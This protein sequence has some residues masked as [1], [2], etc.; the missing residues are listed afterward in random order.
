[1]AY[2]PSLKKLQYLVK[3]YELQHFGKTAKACFVSQSTLSAGI[4]DLEE[5][6]GR[7]LIERNRQNMVFTPTG[8][9]LVKQA[10]EIL[11]AANQFVTTAEKADQFFEGTLRLGVIP[12]IAPYVLPAYLKK[13]SKVY[14]KLKILVREDLSDPLLD[15]LRA[16]ELDLLIIALPYPSESVESIELY[17]D[18]LQLVYNKNSIYTDGIQNNDL[19]NLPN[20]SVLLLEDGH[21]LK[22]HILSTCHLFSNKQINDFSTNSLASIIEMVQYD[23]GIS[24]IPRMAIN[25]GILDGTDITILSD[26]LGE[27]HREIGLVWRESS[28]FREEYNKLGKHLLELHL[29][30]DLDSREFTGSREP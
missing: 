25:N 6:L 3:L 30:S 16:A 22:T 27:A 14:P 20:N 28:P 17:T 29:D 26:P 23:M 1:V 21:C 5:K 4:S 24:F 9:E 19:T 13:L 8:V 2:L 11:N 12:T 7:V 15:R 18:R 10:E